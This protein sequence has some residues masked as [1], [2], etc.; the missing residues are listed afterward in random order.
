MSMGVDDFHSLHGAAKMAALSSAR[1]GRE[2]ASKTAEIE[3]K[4]NFCILTS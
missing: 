2:D 4:R 1:E 3:V